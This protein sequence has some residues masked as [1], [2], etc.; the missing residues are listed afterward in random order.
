MLETKIEAGHVL[1]MTIL[2]VSVRILVRVDDASV[3]TL[4]HLLYK[5]NPSA[6]TTQESGR[7]TVRYQPPT[8]HLP[9]VLGVC[10]PSEVE[11]ASV[12]VSRSLGG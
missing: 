11:E 4:S 10:A 6:E 7:L 5:T 3:R 12:K 8:L 2:E 1:V 9:L